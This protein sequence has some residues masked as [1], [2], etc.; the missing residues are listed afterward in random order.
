MQRGADNLREITTFRL[1]L[2]YG[3]Q[4][5]DIAAA[6]TGGNNFLIYVNYY[7]PGNL[8]GGRG[9]PEEFGGIMKC[10]YADGHVSCF[11]FKALQLGGLVAVDGEVQGDGVSKMAMSRDGNFLV[12]TY[13]L[14][15]QGNS[16][17][18]GPFESWIVVWDIG[19]GDPRE[20]ARVK[21]D[22][23]AEFHG[24]LYT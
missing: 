2:A 3:L 15:Q 18:I 22:V 24:W 16:D 10:T 1:S 7:K 21:T 23:W 8:A 19:H 4:I 5:I 17:F 11:K 12:M 6:P 20:V 14:K 9:D 13:R